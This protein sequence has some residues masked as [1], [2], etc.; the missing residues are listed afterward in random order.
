LTSGE[1]WIRY[2]DADGVQQIVTAST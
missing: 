1:F 2:I